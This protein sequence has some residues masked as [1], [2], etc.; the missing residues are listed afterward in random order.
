MWLSK[1]FKIS[2]PLKIPEVVSVKRVSKADW[3][4]TKKKK[5]LKKVHL[6]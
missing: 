6:V 3:Q 1:F 5:K 2:N 4:F